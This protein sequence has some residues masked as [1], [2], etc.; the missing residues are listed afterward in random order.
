M[1]VDIIIDIPKFAT[2]ADAAMVRR[3]FASSLHPLDATRTFP[4]H[5]QTM[6][7]RNVHDLTGS[8]VGRTSSLSVR[9]NEGEVLKTDVRLPQHG[10]YP[11][12][13]R[14]HTVLEPRVPAAA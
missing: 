13:L 3:S 6:G 4:L 2:S 1:T 14:A 12:V 9:I 8:P 7:K 5:L 10:V 11:W